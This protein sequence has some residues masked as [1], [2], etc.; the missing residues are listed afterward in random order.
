[1]ASAQNATEP[2]ATM[3]VEEAAS[4]LGIGRSLAYQLAREGKIPAMRLGHRLVVSKVALE[5]FLAEGLNPSAS[6]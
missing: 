4:L 3:T 2:A 5:R 1:M 6:R